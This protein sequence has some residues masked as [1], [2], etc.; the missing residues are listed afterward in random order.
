MLTPKKTPSL[1]PFQRWEI[2]DI[3]NIF[4]LHEVVNHSALQA[5]LLA[6]EHPVPETELHL[7]LLTTLKEQLLLNV[8]TWNEEELKLK[9]IAQIMFIVNYDQPPLY[10]SFAERPLKARLGDVQ[11]GGNVDFMVA[12]G[13]ARPQQPFF[14]LHEYKRQRGRD[15]DPLAQL[16]IEMMAARELNHL[17][18]TL[19][20]CYVLGADWYFVILDGLQYSVSRAYD[21][22]QQD[23]F[24]VVAIL[25]QI[26]NYIATWL[27]ESGVQAA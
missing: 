17:Q 14:F 26:K 19:Y 27:G 11:V 16:L 15:G 10:K 24:S 8:G 18:R 4:H 3:V 1:I 23:I 25:R 13:I 9:F 20:G 22:S 21:A 6:G 7:S 5:W 2:D 12:T